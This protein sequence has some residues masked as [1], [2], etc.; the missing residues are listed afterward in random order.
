MRGNKLG[1]LLVIVL[2]LPATPT[3]DE[4]ARIRATFAHLPTEYSS[5]PLWVWNDMLTDDMV[6]GTLR[7][8]AAQHVR[9][10]FVH[11]RPGLMT[12]YLSPEWF[13]L[14]KVALDEAARL[15]MKLWI[16]DENSYPSGF[17]GGFVPEAMPESRGRGLGFKDEAAPRWA[18]DTLAVFRVADAGY[19]D[20]SSQVRA[21]TTLPPARYIVASLLRARPGP[22]YG[23]RYYVDLLYP[24]VTEKFLSITLDAYKREIGGEFGKR[25]PGVFTD[26][27]ELRPAGGLPWTER[28]PALFQERWGYSLTA[29]LPALREPLGDWKRVRHNYYQVLLEQFIE[30]W[31]RPY[32]DYCERNRLEFTGHY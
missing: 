1:L 30:R 13:R 12:P 19:E 15:D 26:E 17:A 4:S 10:V 3:S 21:G 22:W 23:G 29:N 20:V 31:A 6:R 14:W 16:Y 9:Q 2:A 28:L 7:D 27:P 25:V 11:P 24:G 8:L 5:A 18:E 32:Y